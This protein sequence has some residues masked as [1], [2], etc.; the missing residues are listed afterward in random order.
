VEL[1]LL[2]VVVLFVG[3]VGGYGVRE[4]ISQRRQAAYVRRIHEAHIQRAPTQR[5]LNRWRTD[6]V[7]LAKL[8]LDPGE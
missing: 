1:M 4:Y 2:V 6:P 7:L 3:F 8:G 5:S